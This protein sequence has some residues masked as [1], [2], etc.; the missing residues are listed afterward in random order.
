[1]SE[2][3]ARIAPLALL[4]LAAAATASCATSSS[5]ARVSG[6]K[7][8]LVARE[9]VVQVK[10]D[11]RGEVVITPDPTIVR[12]GQKLVISTCC[13]ELKITWKRPVP[14]IPKPPRC[15][16]GECTLVGP[17]VREPVTVDYAIFGT[18]GGKRFERD[19]RFIFTP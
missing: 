3:H 18:C 4:L 5:T 17:E 8:P 15:E 9:V 6:E 7:Q 10:V 12:T 14:E 19:P 1:M 16:G 2:R 13:E 11:G